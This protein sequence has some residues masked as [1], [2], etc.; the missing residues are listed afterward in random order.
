MKDNVFSRQL[1]EEELTLQAESEKQL[2]ANE[3]ADQEF[4]S[5]PVSNRVIQEIEI[6]E[7]R[8]NNFFKEN[9]YNPSLELQASNDS[10]KLNDL[11]SAL[12]I[13]QKYRL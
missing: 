12:F 10:N 7:D 8:L 9:S 6:V 5:G 3:L 11:K 1:T 13:L 2:K 4:N